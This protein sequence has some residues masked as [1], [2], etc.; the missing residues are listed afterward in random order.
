[1]VR[2]IAPTESTMASVCRMDSKVLMTLIYIYITPLK[3]HLKT[4]DTGI[5]INKP[6]KNHIIKSV[7][8]KIKR[9]PVHSC[10]SHTLAHK[11]FTS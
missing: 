5:K 4:P 8:V 9:A 10:I 6:K 7:N 1:M 11:P 2:I 3:R